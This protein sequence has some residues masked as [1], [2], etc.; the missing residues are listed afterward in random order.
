MI[1]IRAGRSEF[2]TLYITSRLEGE[3]MNDKPWLS[4]SNYVKTFTDKNNNYLFMTQL[5]LSTS[6]AFQFIQE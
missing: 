1:D 3:R 6:I 5:T 2:I 4:A